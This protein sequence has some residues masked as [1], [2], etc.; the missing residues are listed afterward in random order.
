MTPLN[1]EWQIEKLK[2]LSREYDRKLLFIY[3]SK[4]KASDLDLIQESFPLKPCLLVDPDAVWQI[5]LEVDEGEE[6]ICL[7]EK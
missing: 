2:E 5:L 7:S 6:N 3:N 1:K 4:K